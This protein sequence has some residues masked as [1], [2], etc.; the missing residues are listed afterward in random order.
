MTTFWTLAHILKRPVFA[1]AIREEIAPA[2]ETTGCSGPRAGAALADIVKKHLTDSCPLLNSAFNEVLRVTSTGSTVREVTRPVKIG[3]KSV[4]KGTKVLLPTRQLHMAPEAFGP[5]AHEVDL[6]RFLKDKTLERHEF[7][8]P[9]GG[10]I[11]SCR[12]RTIGK[13]EVLTFVALALWRYD[14]QVVE[15]GQEALGIKGMPFPRVDTAKP[16]LGISKQVEGDDIIV[17]VT[18]R[19]G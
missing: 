19:R 5:D 17:K 16:S 8:R 11:T 4:Y 7:Y 1:T 18:A 13:R 2:M 12:G 14:M 6:S 10:G 15:P 9:F 3:D